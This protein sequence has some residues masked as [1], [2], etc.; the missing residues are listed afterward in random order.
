MAGNNNAGVLNV[1]SMPKSITAFAKNDKNI[2]EPAPITAV[3]LS[4]HDMLS[5]PNELIEALFAYKYFKK[6]F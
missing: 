4:L 1:S 6:L 5:F 3:K 2:Y